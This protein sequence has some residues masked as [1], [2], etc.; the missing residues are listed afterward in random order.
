MLTYTASHLDEV[1]AATAKFC[2]EVTDPKAAIITAYNF[3]FGQVR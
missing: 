3:V 1:S 2:T